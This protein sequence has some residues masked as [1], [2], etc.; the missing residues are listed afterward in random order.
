MK[1]RLHFGLLFTLVLS[2]AA[3]PSAFAWG[4]HGHAVAGRAAALKM[5]EQ[6][7]KFF[8]QSVGQLSYLNPEPDRWRDRAESAVSPALNAVS[9]P[10]HYI[11]LELVPEGGLNAPDRYALISELIKA[12]RKPSEAGFLPFCIL[13]QFQRLRVEFRLWRAEQ[14]AQKRAWIEQ[15]I[16]NDAG[17]LGHYVADGANPHHTTIHHNGWVGENPKG[18]TT[19]KDFHYRFESEFVQTH[20]QLSDVLPRVGVEARV[21]ENPREAINAFLR[22]SHARLEEL[23]DLEKREKFNAATTG[24]D[25]KKFAAAR[26][27]AGAAMLRD[28]WWT[29]WVTSATAAPP[30][31]K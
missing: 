19:E 28:L 20:I 6:V 13:E 22:D 9:A 31:T 25:H 26:L 15:R 3:P 17:I 23:Y 14:D 8:R 24:T 18:Y 5:P 12:G 7:P 16:V 10:D 30:V 11:D 1:Q 4:E 29:A 27:A 21:L 2:L